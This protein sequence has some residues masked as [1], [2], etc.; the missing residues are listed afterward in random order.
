M[1]NKKV[2]IIL[3]GNPNSGKTSLFNSL[4]GLNQKVGNYPGV[5]VD[6]T[7]GTIVLGDTIIAN[8]IDLPGIYGMYPKSEDEIVAHK[9]LVQNKRDS[10]I[11]LVVVVADASN[12]KRSLLLL[13]QIMDLNLPVVLALSMM[14]IA[15]K[16]GIQINTQQ[17]SEALGIPVAVINPRKNDGIDA[18]KQTLLHTLQQKAPVVGFWEQAI[19]P[20]HLQ[21]VANELQL[22]SNYAALLSLGNTQNAFL[23]SKEQQAWL[24]AYIKQHDLKI[25]QLQGEDII[26]RYDKIG[27]IT[28][29]AITKIP[30]RLAKSAT[31]TIDKWLLHPV[32]GY[33]IMFIIMFVVFQSIFWLAS[34]PMDWIDSL[35]GQ[36]A[37]WASDILPAD[38]WYSG[39]IADGIISGLGGIVIFV[40]QIAI[41]FFFIS[42]LEDTGYMSRISYLTD[43]IMRAAGMNGRSMMPLI[44]GM[45][46]AIPAVMAARTIRDPK[47]RLITILVTP[48]MACSARLP[49]YTLLI[50]MFI[51]DTILWGLFNMQG[52][53]MMALYVLG[54]V[55]A[56]LVAFVLNK[57]IQKKDQDFFVMELPLYRAPRW[58]NAIITMIDK[59]KI[60]VMDAGKIIL[61]LSI[62]L[63]FLASYGPSQQMERIDDKYEQLAAQQPE[64]LTELQTEALNNEKLSASYAGILGRTI[65]PAIAPLGY[66]WK[67]GIALISSFAAR[68][69]FVGTMATLYAVG[70]ADDDPTP[71][72]QKL[73]EAQRPDGSKVYT[74]ATGMSLLMFY[75]FA[76][77]CVSTI[78]IV[79]R[80]T[81]SWKWTLT[82]VVYLTG[83]AY[84]MAWL[85]FQ[86]FQ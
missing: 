4:T 2:N 74:L 28:Q 7:S 83:L 59:A 75:A 45:A 20:E 6:K 54:I 33:I 73:L 29:S 77:Q 65:E 18:F 49:V 27:R 22:R 53:V 60:F 68:E 79:K 35:F 72:K 67:I 34:F 17:L 81:K 8:I 82:Q 15:P 21:A 3:A 39:L 11:D 38:A 70:G 23:S 24:E 30:D 85:A 19:A 47:E 37:S 1:N 71:L 25:H 78:A 51:P 31:K 50:S 41:L 26:N 43:R 76:M 58:E 5:T 86:I 46:C 69:V 36:L 12:L 13:S 40:P 16:K 42:V 55:A 32:L 14:D 80:E 84:F 64:G 57:I 56:M 66:D 10:A 63:W 61:V 44:S 9:V 52:L 62:V 48:L